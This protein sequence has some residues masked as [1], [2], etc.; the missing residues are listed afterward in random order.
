MK[1]QK[2]IA[3]ILAA[4]V[5]LGACSKNGNTQETTRKESTP[6][7][8]A[9][10]DGS[11]ENTKAEAGSSAGTE[12]MTEQETSTET[13]STTSEPEFSELLGGPVEIRSHNDIY[14]IYETAEIE[15][16]LP[17]ELLLMYFTSSKPYTGLPDEEFDTVTTITMDL[18]TGAFDGSYTRPGESKEI[19]GGKE[20]EIFMSEFSGQ[21]EAFT[22]IDDHSFSVKVSELE[23]KEFDSFTQTIE[24]QNRTD[25]EHLS[26]EDPE[27]FTEPDEM[28]LYL[29][30]TKKDEIPDGAIKQ[31]KKFGTFSESEFLDQFILYNPTEES[32]FLIG[33]GMISDSES[34]S[35]DDLKDWYGDYY[36]LGGKMNVKYDDALGCVTA[37][38]TA[39]DGE[40]YKLFVEQVKSE[41]DCI[42]FYGSSTRGASLV[43]YL[44]RFDDWYDVYLTVSS[45]SSVRYYPERTVAVK[46]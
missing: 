17:E 15:A 24:G 33:E 27:G 13:E 28:I 1:R 29:P 10:A 25:V 19:G 8:T 20:S 9:A 30:N 34:S 35:A 18:N 7:T 22:R 12:S 6:K 2:W 41:P 43:F 37:S 14:K 32:F 21:M 46:R 4:S 40:Q 3:G 26:F 5:L 39:E 38:F 45:G 31:I 42:M 11:E 16:M 36:L 44:W 23:I